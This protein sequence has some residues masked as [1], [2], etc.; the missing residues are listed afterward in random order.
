M[1]RELAVVLAHAVAA[2]AIG[3]WYFRAARLPRPPLGVLDLGDV[4]ILIAASVAVPYLYLLLPVWLAGALLL[5]VELGVLQAFWGPLTGNRRIA[6]GVTLLLIG[7][8]V[9]AAW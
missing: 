5:T 7:G 9:A 4:V 1:Q 8:D 3:W 6:W 2:V